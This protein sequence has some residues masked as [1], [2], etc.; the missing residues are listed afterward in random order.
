MRL[1]WQVD[2]NVVLLWLLILFFPEVVYGIEWTYFGWRLDPIFS[3]NE[4][5]NDNPR[6][7]FEQKDAGFITTVSPGLLIGRREERW[8]VNL[9]AKL[10]YEIYNGVDV[11]DRDSERIRLRSHLH[12]TERSFFQLNGSYVRDTLLRR[13]FIE[14]DEDFLEPIEDIDIG[15]VDVSTRRNRVQINP[16]W[17]YALTERTSVQLGYGFTDLSYAESEEINLINTQQH[18]LSGKG[19]YELTPISTLS[20]NV[21]ATRRT[22]E[23]ESETDNLEALVGWNHLFSETFQS[24]ARAGY[25]ITSA[26]SNDEEEISSGFVGKL[27]IRYSTELGLLRGSI[28]RTV[29]PSGNGRSNQTDRIRIQYTQTIMPRLSFVL[30]ADAFRTESVE[31]DFSQGERRYFDVEPRLLWNW[32]RWWAVEVGYHYRRRENE[33][34][35]EFANSNAVFVAITYTPLIER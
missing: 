13:V 23:D 10:N 33:S 25:R 6:L 32:T 18:L 2:T 9:G 12:F 19:F 14:I 30:R 15:L 1:F 17:R 24:E 20:L 26:S 34:P 29:T 31:D 7:S 16:S 22:S 8:E 21:N 11:P 35:S 3:L 4:E 27:V 28:S 5:F